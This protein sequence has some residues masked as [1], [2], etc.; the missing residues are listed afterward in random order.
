MVLDEATANV[1]V[2]TDAL[3]QRTMQT[4]FADRTIIAVAHRLH[5]I[6]EYDRCV[7][8]ARTGLPATSRDPPAAHHHRVPQVGAA[9][10]LA[11]PLACGARW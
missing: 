3:I 11:S 10:A 5:T 4:Q 7:T 1:D 8:L 2:E 6:I 9:P